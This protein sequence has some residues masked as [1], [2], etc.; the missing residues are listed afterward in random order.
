M[1]YFLLNRISKSVLIAGINFFS[2]AIASQAEDLNQLQ[3]DLNQ[4]NSIPQINSVSQLRDISPNDWAYQALGN[5][6]EN[7]DCLEGYPDRTFRGDRTL[8]RY[9]FAAGLNACLEAINGSNNQDLV[10]N[11]EFEQI[12]RLIQEFQTELTTLGTR[13]DDLEGKVA[14][15]EN[16]QFSTTTKLQGEMIMAATAVSTN[17]VNGSDI[18]NNL[19]FGQRTRL[20][21]ITSL[22][23]N[24]QLL[25]RLESDN[26]LNPNLNTPEGSFAFAGD[27][28]NTDL[29]I[30]ALV[31]KF[32]LGDQTH[33]AI[34]A[35][36]GASDEFAQTFNFLD[37]DGSQGAL[38]TFGTRHPI[39]FQV[40]DKGIGI[41][42]QF[43]HWLTLSLGYMAADAND[44]AKGKSLFNGSYGAMAQ[45]EI[46]PH[47]DLHIGL[48][49]INAYN[50]TDTGTGSNLANFRAFTEQNLGSPV[51]IIGNS[52]GAQLSW[53][54][55][56]KFVLGG[57]VGYSNLKTLSDLGGA[58]SKGNLEVWNWAFNLAFPDLFK[59]GNTAGIIIGMEPKVTHSTVT[60]PAIAT[61]DQSTSLHIEALYQISLND[62]LKITPS[63]IW[64]TA[65]DHNSNNND[66]VIATIRTL[67]TF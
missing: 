17:Q 6:V 67:F 7:Y 50:Q 42:H 11:D 23:G 12:S 60:I 33:V 21:L 48:T 4:E 24:D 63:V 45:L 38:S 20:N 55:D 54:L 5:L 15:L 8:S 66:V 28:G 43:A 1:T 59:E 37:G 26:I 36:A 16:N 41:N 44:P 57:W 2:L 31:Y 62:H 47:D 52:Y 53:H 14:T 58:I 65:P 25:T 32:P 13:V 64:L 30:D 18:D 40:E 34:A 29:Y 49:Y 35:N 3:N 27:T 46:Q 22:S 51:P 9:E 39:Y 56:P 61:Q 10:S 19:T